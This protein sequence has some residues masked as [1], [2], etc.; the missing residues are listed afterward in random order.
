MHKAWTSE[1]DRVGKEALG[2][3]RTRHLEVERAHAMADVENHAMQ[4]RSPDV[5]AKLSVALPDVVGERL[6]AMGEHV[7]FA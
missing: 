2:D 6:E 1:G 3:G 7:A 5:G 4:A